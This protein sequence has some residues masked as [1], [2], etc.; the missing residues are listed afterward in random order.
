MAACPFSTSGWI[1][2]WRLVLILSF[3]YRFPNTLSQGFLI[4]TLVKMMVMVIPESPDS[5][6]DHKVKCQC[7]I[8]ICGIHDASFL[9]YRMLS[10]VVCLFLVLHQIQSRCP[11]LSFSGGF[12]DD[13]VFLSC[14]TGPTLDATH[15]CDGDVT[16]TCRFILPFVYF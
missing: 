7:L 15:V 10:T 2:S 11:P 3:S 1:W 5:A 8:F 14:T 9:I 4:H 16:G 12:S 13:W 6:S